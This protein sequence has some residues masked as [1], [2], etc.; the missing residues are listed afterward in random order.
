MKFTPGI[1]VTAKRAVV[2]PASVYLC[3]LA[4]G[5]Y[6]EIITT[7]FVLLEVGNWLSRRA[8]IAMSF[9]GCLRCSTW[10]RKQR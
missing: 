1:K 10:I 5:F 2:H 6:G 8:Q 4:Q 7:D 3:S 9:S